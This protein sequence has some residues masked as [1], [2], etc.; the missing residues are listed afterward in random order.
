MTAL[1]TAAMLLIYWRRGLPSLSA[2]PAPEVLREA[3]ED[4]YHLRP[5]TA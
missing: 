2:E 3:A 4:E 1:A 5:D